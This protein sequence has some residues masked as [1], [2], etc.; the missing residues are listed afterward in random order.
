MPL[1]VAGKTRTFESSQI[2]PAQS[3]LQQSNKF[4]AECEYI[5]RR[6]APFFNYSAKVNSPNKEHRLIRQAV[7]DRGI[8]FERSV[9]AV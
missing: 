5:Y 3:Y 9:R 7:Q 6:F 8:E 4:I 1:A 2:S